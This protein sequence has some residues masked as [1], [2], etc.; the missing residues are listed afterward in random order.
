[1]NLQI[2]ADFIVR[3][4]RVSW[5]EVQFGLEQHLMN[6]HAA[7][8]FAIEEVGKLDEPSSLLLELA[9]SDA[10]DPIADLVAKLAASEPSV[11][12]PVMRDKWLYLTLAWLY[13][14]RE[15]LTNPL[16]LLEEV[17]TDFGYPSEMAAFIRYM[18]M[19]GPDLGSVDANERRM[20][21]NWKTYV[22]AAQAK[23]RS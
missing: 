21:T 12:E 2:P 10:S 1:M 16:E 17:Y 13:E 15:A 22:D 5:R 18:P 9:G 8:E 20:I 6:V 19:Q 23:Y 4:A 3:R 7:I 11:D 14:R